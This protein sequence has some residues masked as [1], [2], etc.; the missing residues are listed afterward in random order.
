[1]KYV[2]TIY[3]KNTLGP[4]SRRDA[5]RAARWMIPFPAKQSARSTSSRIGSSSMATSSVQRSRSVPSGSTRARMQVVLRKNFQPI[6]HFPLIDQCLNAI[7]ALARSTYNRM[8]AWL[9]DLCNRTLIDPTMKK[10]NFIGILDIAGLKYF[11]SPFL[12]APTPVNGWVS[13]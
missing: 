11:N 10:A 6:Y 8:F 5:K 3:D 13:Q 9:V 2:H 12:D 4:S 1:M 7:A